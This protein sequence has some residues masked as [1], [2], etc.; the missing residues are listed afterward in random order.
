M[1]QVVEHVLGKDEVTG[2]N[3]VISSRKR[4]WFRL[5]LLPF[6]ACCRAEF[7]EKW[8]PRNLRFWGEE[9]QQSALCSG[10]CAKNHYKQVAFATTRLSA[11]KNRL[12][13]PFLGSAQ[14]VLFVYSRFDV[15]FGFCLIIF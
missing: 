13:K 4:Q 6:Y 14:A 10:F 11:P 8:G 15:Y 1:A 9:E 12:D 3:P 7:N 2:S 5:G